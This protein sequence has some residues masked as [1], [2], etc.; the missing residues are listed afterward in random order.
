MEIGTRRGSRLVSG[1]PARAGDGCPAGM[2]R[3][4]Q[5]VLV[6]GAAG[7]IGAAL[8]L[9]L[10]E[11]G[12]EVV[13]VDNLDPSCD[14]SLK[15]ARLDRIRAFA[16]FHDIRADIADRAAMAA[17]FARERPSAV[18]HLA[19]RAGVRTCAENPEDCVDV[20]LAGFVNVLEGCRLNGVGHLVYASSSA[21]YGAG[22][23][24]PFPVGAAADRPLSLYAATKR[25]NELMAHSYAAFHGLRT[26]GLRLSSV[27]GP[28]GRPD[29]ALSRFTR[30]IL[31]GRAVELYNAGRH[32]RDFTYIDDAVEGM[33]RV[34]DRPRDAGPCQ[35]TEGSGPVAAS[36]RV[37]N[38]GT[39]VPVG[40]GRVVEI[41]E[42][43]LGREAGRR[44]LPLQR[45]DIPAAV[46]DV[47]DLLAAVGYRPATTV[48]TG[49]PRFV[50]WYREF[51]GER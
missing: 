27:Y 51:H 29:M 2:S 22:T 49:I 32:S 47:D 26:T 16:G 37:Y 25:A 44:L 10:L 1:E 21:V 12:D 8:A 36:H 45:G 17:L 23:A 20:N 28:W 50:D 13:G 35:T 30:S 3:P 31:E 6:T 33:V 15:R 9:R 38:V 18:V 40:I 42:D 11:R 43:C 7:F 48:E 24:L 46:A 5:R 14:V 34:L 4:S 19:A 39:G 41:L